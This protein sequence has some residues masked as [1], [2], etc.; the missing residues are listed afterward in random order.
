M[1]ISI[2]DSNLGRN[3]NIA[4]VIE[5][6]RQDIQRFSDAVGG[7]ILHARLVANVASIAAGAEAT[8]AVTVTGAAI[9]DFVD[10]SIIDATPTS[11]SLA[12][13]SLVARVSAADTVTIT[14]SNLHAATALDLSAA[15]EFVV[16]VRGVPS[17]NKLNQLPAAK[18][19]A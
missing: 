12:D 11:G 5:G 1:A 15:A 19:S 4:D 18:V 9:G 16:V 7:K 13:A 14:I 6:L 17:T 10:V 8:Q 3:E 2:A